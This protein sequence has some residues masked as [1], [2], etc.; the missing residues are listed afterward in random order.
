MIREIYSTWPSARRRH[1]SGPFLN[2]RIR[3]LSHLKQQGYV[4][5][6][7]RFRASILLVIAEDTDLLSRE[8]VSRSEVKKQ[9]SK[10]VKAR[11]AELKTGIF[12]L[13]TCGA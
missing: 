12:A 5:T 13:N 10:S 4:R 8:T 11:D 7:L 1:E 9:I 6:S 3:F 2:E